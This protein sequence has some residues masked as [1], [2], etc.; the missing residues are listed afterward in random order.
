MLYVYVRVGV[1]YVWHMGGNVPSQLGRPLLAP[2]AEPGVCAQPSGE[3]AAGGSFRHA[4]GVVISSET[5]FH[6]KT[7]LKGV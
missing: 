1:P 4:P 2:L 6:L 7:Y 5:D 3:H